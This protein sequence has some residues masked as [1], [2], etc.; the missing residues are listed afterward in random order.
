MKYLEYLNNE[1]D[2]AKA[3]F[4]AAKKEVAK[5]IEIMTVHNA[6]DYSG[7]YAAHVDKITAA[8]A[9][10]RALAEAKHVYGYIN[11]GDER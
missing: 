7:A 10:F 8:A 3:D 4:E 2:R 6:V 1:I 5:E 11:G 9:R